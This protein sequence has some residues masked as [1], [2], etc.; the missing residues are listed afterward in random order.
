[1]TELIKTQG[2]IKR[3]GDITAVNGI[4]LSVQRGEVLGFLGPNGAGKSTTMKM[5]T[6]FLT[7]DAGTVAVRGIDMAAQPMLAKAAIGYL[8]EGAYYPDFLRGDEPYKQGWGAEP[9]F[10]ARI[11]MPVSV[12]GRAILAARR[13]VKRMQAPGSRRR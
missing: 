8:P 7:P 11:L 1:M 13:T 12:K 10:D 9:R 2:L 3:F 4:S 6:G 5:I